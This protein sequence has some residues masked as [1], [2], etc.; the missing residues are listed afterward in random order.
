MKTQF[1]IVAISLTALTLGGCG[2][3]DEP[4]PN[5]TAAAA[6]NSMNSLNQAAPAESAGQAFA[7]AAAASDAFEIQSSQL[8]EANSRSAA[9]KKFAASMIKAHTDSTAK[10]SQAASSASPAIMPRPVLTPE[11]QQTLDALRTKTGPDFD[12]AYIQAQTKAHQQ[13]LDTLKS[14]SA[15]G[16]VPALKEFAADLVPIVTAHLN[17]AKGLKS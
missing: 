10:L 11:Q 1:G 3:K 16:D 2:K 15:S 7:N 12:A 13:T 8:A 14:Y 17:M 6:V 4:A 5:Q 9:V